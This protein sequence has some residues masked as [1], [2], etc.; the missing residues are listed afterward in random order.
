MIMWNIH[1]PCFNHHY[2]GFF[3]HVGNR[4]VVHSIYIVIYS[5]VLLVFA[6]DLFF[7]SSCVINQNFSDCP[8]G[9]LL[10]VPSLFHIPN[11]FT[12]KHSDRSARILQSVE[13]TL[14]RSPRLVKIHLG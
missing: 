4:N 5:P 6:D 2:L 10:G 1:L 12:V 11:G 8:L 13:K 7:F 3:G 14:A 9:S